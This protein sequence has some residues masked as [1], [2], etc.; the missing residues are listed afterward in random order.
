MDAEIETPVQQ[1]PECQEDWPG[2]PPSPLQPWPWPSQPWSS[3]HIDYAGPFLGHMFLV[4]IDAHSKWIEVFP[5]RAATSNP[6]IQQLRIT[7]AQFGIP[8]TVVSDN[9][10]C[11]VS[12]EFEEFLSRNGIKHLKSAPYHPASNRLAERGVQIFKT[13]MKKMKAGSLTD[14]IARVLFNYRITPQTTTGLSLAELLMSRRLN[15]RMDLMVPS[16]SRRVQ[17]SQS[18]HKMTHDFHASDREVAEGDRVYARSFAPRAEAKWLPGEAVQKTGPLSCQVQLQDGT[19]WRR[20]QD[21]I[22]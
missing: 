20:H 5:V 16:V 19:V 15:S 10:Q 7:F 9:G 21:H 18:Q 13:G 12:A 22:R 4:L 1:C 17:R 6:T 3:L 2:P 8:E 14:R 11:F